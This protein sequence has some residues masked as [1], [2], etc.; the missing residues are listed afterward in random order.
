MVSLCIQASAGREMIFI[1]CVHIYLH[2]LT[3]LARIPFIATQIAKVPGRYVYRFSR[4]WVHF[5]SYNRGSGC[6]PL[7]F[8]SQGIFFLKC[9]FT[10]IL[11]E[12]VQISSQ[13]SLYQFY[14]VCWCKPECYNLIWH[15]PVCIYMRCAIG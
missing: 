8:I 7:G 9:P 6:C 12:T 4:Y 14:F 3:T 13:N 11:R 15:P 10:G 2:P 1:G 5:N